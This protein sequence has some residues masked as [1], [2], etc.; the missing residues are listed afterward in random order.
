MGISPVRY[1]RKHDQVAAKLV[2]VRL[3]RSNRLAEGAKQ[4][5]TQYKKFDLEKAKA[6]EPIITR[7]GRPARF[8]AHVPDAIYKS[9]RLIVLVNR[10]MQGRYIGGNA[11]TDRESGG[12][13]VMAP[14]PKVRK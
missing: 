13:I 11:T 10:C 5:T 3:E 14:K 8:I 7:D 4:M 6:G 9:E 1:L 12:D 2:P